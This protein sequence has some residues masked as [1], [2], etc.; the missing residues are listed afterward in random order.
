M[1]F[2]ENVKIDNIFKFYQIL[3]EEYGEVISHI[4]FPEYSISIPKNEDEFTDMI[5]EL[6]WNNIYYISLF[7]KPKIMIKFDFL[8]EE[9]NI[10]CESSELENTVEKL[11]KQNF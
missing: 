11:I 1:K 7:I 8:T 9:I 3:I 10:K 6:G 4:K 5:K 2:P